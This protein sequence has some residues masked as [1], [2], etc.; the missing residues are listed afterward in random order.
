MSKIITLLLAI[1]SLNLMSQE[2]KVPQWFLNDIK[3][4]QGVWVADNSEYKSDQE[5]Y[6]F[7][8]SEWELGIDNK[9]LIGKLYGKN[10]LNQK[11]LFWEFRQYWDNELQKAIVIQFGNNNII[12]K[13]DLYPFDNKKMVSTQSFSMSDGRTWVEKHETTINKDIMITTSFEQLSD[14]SWKKK[15]TYKWLKQKQLDLGRFSMSL[16]VNDLKVSMKFYKDLGFKVLDGKVEQNWITMVNNDIK[17]GLFKGMFPKNT[18]T[19]N[20]KNA[21]DFYHLLKKNNVTIL[22][23]QGINKNEGACSFSFLDPDG[24]PILID[25]HY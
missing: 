3:K 4:I 8:I 12:G 22:F 23:E 5:P 9:S 17:I 20:P 11:F 21:R 2:K 1:I 6:T 24:N 13:G 15:R 18:I 14:N 16:A 19:F 10:E 7:Y 25:Q